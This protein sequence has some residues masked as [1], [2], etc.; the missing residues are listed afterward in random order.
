M[1][2]FKLKKL[3]PIKFEYRGLVFWLDS[4]PTLSSWNKVRTEQMTE[5]G[6]NPGEITE[7][8]EDVQTYWFGKAMIGTMVVGIDSF[9]IEQ[10]DGSVD[11]FKF[12]APSDDER[13]ETQGEEFIC[14][15]GDIQD[16]VFERVQKLIKNK[17]AY[18]VK[19][20]GNS[21][22]PADSGD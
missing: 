11:V 5:A 14:V 1:S 4:E 12:D 3:D 10:Q 20:L 9:E 16:A 13:F 21:S 22:T 8:D 17:P 19:A 6:L 18:E 2:R 7:M 15:N